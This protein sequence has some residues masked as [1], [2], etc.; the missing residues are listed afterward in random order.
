MVVQQK[1]Q[2]SRSRKK[3]QKTVLQL[4]CYDLRKGVEKPV[5][6][7]KIEEFLLPELDQEQD[8]QENNKKSS[9][10]KSAQSPLQEMRQKQ[11]DS[12]LKQYNITFSYQFGPASLGES[13]EYESENEFLDNQYFCIQQYV[14]DR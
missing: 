3:Q 4:F 5:E 11:D 9:L 8:E 12:R 1:G 13:A 7:V 2:G 6:R 10:V 14:M